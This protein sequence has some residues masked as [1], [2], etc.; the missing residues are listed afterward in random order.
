MQIGRLLIQYHR[1]PKFFGRYRRYRTRAP[2]LI[3]FWWGTKFLFDVPMPKYG[4]EW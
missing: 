3:R 4:S 2:S 1:M